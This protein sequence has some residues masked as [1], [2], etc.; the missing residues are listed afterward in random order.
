MVTPWQSAHF[1]YFNADRSGV[2]PVEETPIF[3]NLGLNDLG[4]KFKRPA[5]D[6]GHGSIHKNRKAFI[7]HVLPAL[8]RESQTESDAGKNVYEEASTPWWRCF[9][10][11]K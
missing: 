8:T 5:I 3:S 2:V 11:C 1:G 7:E 4:S 10:C 6:I 9:V